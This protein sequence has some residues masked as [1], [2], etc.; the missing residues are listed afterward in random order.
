M[1]SLSMKG[2]AL[3][4]ICVRLKIQ[5]YVVILQTHWVTFIGHWEQQILLMVTLAHNLMYKVFNV[6]IKTI[7]WFKFI[8]FYS[9]SILLEMNWEVLCILMQKYTNF[10]RLFNKLDL[11]PQSNKNLRDHVCIFII[12]H[13]VIYKIKFN[14]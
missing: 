10:N 11:Y 14:L 8:Q 4:Q 13:M 5:T 3:P 1:I 7:S 6:T 12:M 2:N 9:F